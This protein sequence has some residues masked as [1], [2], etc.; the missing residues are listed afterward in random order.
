MEAISF[1]VSL[2]SVADEESEERGE[3]RTDK[4]ET[5]CTELLLEKC[6]K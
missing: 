5:L 6:Y 3:L 1:I 4:E 2:R